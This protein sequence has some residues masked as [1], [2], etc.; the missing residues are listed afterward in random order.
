MMGASEPCQAVC[1][2][3]PNNSRTYTETLYLLTNGAPTSPSTPVGENH[4][5]LHADEVEEGTRKTL[6]GV[7]LSDFELQICLS[8]KW[9]VSG[10]WLKDNIW[11]QRVP[12]PPPQ[13][14]LL[15]L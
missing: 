9:A 14:F 4:F 3:V 15:F 8:V 5:V 2:A 13:F 11:L 6:L 10:I 1:H 12:S 7:I